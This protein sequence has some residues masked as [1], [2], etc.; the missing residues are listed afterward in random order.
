LLPVEAVVV[1]ATSD[2][3]NTS[4]GHLEEQ[5]IVSAAIVKDTLGKVNLDA[6]DPSDA[7]SNFVHN[8]DFRKTR[9]LMAVERLDPLAFGNSQ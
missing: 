3:L 1:H 2:L 9:G 4:T 7:M 6:L 5:P 8:M